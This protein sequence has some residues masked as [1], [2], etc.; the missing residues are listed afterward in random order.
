M[1]PPSAIANN[2]GRVKDPRLRYQTRATGGSKT[3]PYDTNDGGWGS[4]ART[5]DAKS[6]SGAG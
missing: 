3:R 4:N 1:Q 2:R 6:P 5:T